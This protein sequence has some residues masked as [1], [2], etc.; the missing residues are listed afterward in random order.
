MN[1]AE[2][3][4]KTCAHIEMTG[5]VAENCTIRKRLMWNGT[6][7]CRSYDENKTILE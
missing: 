2:I 6:R 4:C 5:H 7:Q 1:D 3:L